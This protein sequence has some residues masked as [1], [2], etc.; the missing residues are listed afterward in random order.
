M[1]LNPKT[2]V[3]Y[4]TDNRAQQITYNIVQ[5]TRKITVDPGKEHEKLRCNTG[6]TTKCNTEPEYKQL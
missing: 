6:I 1:V 3:R 2:E 5:I 4:K